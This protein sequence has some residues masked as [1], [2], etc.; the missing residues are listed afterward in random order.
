MLRSNPPTHKVNKSLGFPSTFLDSK[1]NPLIT[2]GSRA[3][4]MKK[5]LKIKLNI[6]NSISYEDCNLLNMMVPMRYIKENTHFQKEDILSF[7]N[8][9]VAKNP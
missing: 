1:G 7:Y 2:R 6:A 4:M 3:M 8:K 9:A 5:L